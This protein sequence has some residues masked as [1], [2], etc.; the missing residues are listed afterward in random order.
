AVAEFHTGE[1]VEAV[2]C[3]EAQEIERA[4]GVVDVGEHGGVVAALQHPLEEVFQ[5]QRAVAKAVVAVQVKEHGAS[6]RAAGRAR[7]RAARRVS[8]WLSGCTVRRTACG[9]GP[10]PA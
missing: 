1:D 3:A 10:S 9:C 7:L 6:F 4:G 5:R 2:L 8:T